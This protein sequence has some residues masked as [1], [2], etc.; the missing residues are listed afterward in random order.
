MSGP[1][2]RENFKQKQQLDAE[3]SLAENGKK[4]VCLSKALSGRLTNRAGNSSSL[5]LHLELDVF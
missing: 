4:K 3:D 1:H 5:H 2:R